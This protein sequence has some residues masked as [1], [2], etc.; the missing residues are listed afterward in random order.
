MNE[1]Q[2][3][4]HINC[5]RQLVEE[6]KKISTSQKLVNKKQEILIKK[7]STDFCENR[8]KN[9]LFKIIAPSIAFSLWL[10]GVIVF[11]Y[12]TIEKQDYVINLIDKCIA[13]ITIATPYTSQERI[14]GAIIDK[15][16]SDTKDTEIKTTKETRCDKL[17]RT[18]S[19]MSKD[20]KDSFKYILCFGVAYVSIVLILMF[21]VKNGYN[22]GG[23]IEKIGEFNVKKVLKNKK[24]DEN[25]E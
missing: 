22:F 11:G 23:K 15:Y 2:D 7:I 10:I 9:I 1:N 4:S 13:E 12:R 6:V 17:V 3:V 18:A 25:N 14:V 16:K 19:F 24:N 5:T 8:A 21:L 20:A